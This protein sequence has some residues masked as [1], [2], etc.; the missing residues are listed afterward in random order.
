MLVSPC[1]R[2]VLSGLRY[3]VHH[4]QLG[5]EGQRTLHCYPRH[6]APLLNWASPEMLH[7]VCALLPYC[8]LLVCFDFTIISINLL[9]YK[10]L[11]YCDSKASINCFLKI[12]IR[13]TYGSA[14]NSQIPVQFMNK[15]HC[16]ILLSKHHFLFDLY[17]GC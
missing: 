12:M 2:A 8:C 16:W 9:Y 1:G 14:F 17:I 5:T 11:T 10:V 6:P 7:Q 15:S 3:S 4:R 13:V